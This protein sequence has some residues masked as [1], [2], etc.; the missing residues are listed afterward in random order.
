MRAGIF[1][2]NSVNTAF[3]FFQTEALFFAIPFAMGSI[4]A[5]TFYSRNTVF[6]FAVYSSFLIAFLFE[7]K[8]LFLIFSLLGGVVAAMH[9][10]Y[11][12][13]RSF[14]IK[15][16]SFRWTHKYYSDCRDSTSL[17]PICSVLH[18]LLNL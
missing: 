2:G 13:Q 16:G 3:G 18:R 10:A 9:M 17:N 15:A 6:I 11:F 12:K 8:I 4:L 14:F 7:S 5:A 1:I